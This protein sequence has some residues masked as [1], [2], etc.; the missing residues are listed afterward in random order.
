M[1]KML[2]EKKKER[3]NRGGKLGRVNNREGKLGMVNNIGGKLGR[4]NT[5]EEN[6]GG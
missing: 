1:Y 2:R 5:E 4:V 3:N 6:W